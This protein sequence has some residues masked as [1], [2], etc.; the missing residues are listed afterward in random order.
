MAAG[1]HLI[2][3][4]L[5]ALLGL[6][7]GYVFYRSPRLR[8]NFRVQGFTVVLI[9]VAATTLLASSAVTIHQLGA[10]GF[11][12]LGASVC[13]LP[14]LVYILLSQWNRLLEYLMAAASRNEDI[15]RQPSD[16]EEW[17]A[18]ERHLE[19]LRDNPINPFHRRQ[20]GEVYLR[21]GLVDSALSEF[22]KTIEC[23]DRGYEEAQLLFKCS[24]LIV[25]RKDD[26]PA[27][28]PILRRIIRLYPKSYFAAYARRI[29]NQYEAHHA[30]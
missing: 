5:Y 21:L 10:E 7:L 8:E 27:A 3:A 16:R 11:L 25:D 23:L 20:L 30:L 29:V 1:L 6:A 13:H 19:A 4:T 24:R 14:T 22:R 15:A 26:V 18:V 17:K 28:I 2:A 9:V 12:F